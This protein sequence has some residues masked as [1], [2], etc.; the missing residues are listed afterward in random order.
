MLVLSLVLQSAYYQLVLTQVLLWAV[1]SLAWNILCGY[2]GY[3][4]FGHAAFWGLGAYTVA[5]GDDLS[6][7]DAVARRSRSARWSAAVAGA[8][9]GYPDLPPARALFRAGDA[10]L[11]AGD[12]LRLPVARL[13]GTDAADEA[14]RRRCSTCSST[15]RASTSCWRWACWWLRWLISLWVENSR[16][17]MSLF[18]IKQNEPAAEAAGIDTWRWKMLALML[19]GRA[20]GDGGRALRGRAAGGDAGDR[21]RHAGLGAGADPGAV[22]RGRQPVGA[23]DRRDG[24]GAARRGAQRRARRRAARHPGR[25]LRRRDHRHHPAARPRASTGACSTGSR[26]RKPRPSRAARSPAAA[27]RRPAA[28]SARARPAATCW[29]CAAS[30]S[31]SAGCARSTRST[32]RVPEG[33]LYGIIGPNGAGKTTLFNVINGFLAPEQRHDQLRRRA[34]HRACGRTRSAGAASAAPFRWCA[35]FR[36]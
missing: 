17:G 33:G 15:T 8:L 1:L 34:A 36:A 35:P 11:S 6:R 21:V 7:P 19:S 28:R 14:R 32:S 30:A 27:G 2:S 24:A 9:I 23:G 12:A 22:R 5:L 31:R 29:C 26:R 10:R 16:F 3:F 25:R 4:S 18:A 20:G 13:S